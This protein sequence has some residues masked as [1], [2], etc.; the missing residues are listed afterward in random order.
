MAANHLYNNIEQL[1]DGFFVL[2]KEVVIRYYDI[3]QLLVKCLQYAT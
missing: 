3:L 2:K 1:H